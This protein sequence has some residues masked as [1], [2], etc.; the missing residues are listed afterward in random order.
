MRCA[1]KLS[2][3]TKVV[4]L[5]SPAQSRRTVWTPEELR[6]LAQFCLEHGLILVSDEIH[7]DLVFDGKHTPTLTAAPEIADSLITCGRR[8]QDLQ[9]RRRPCGRVLHVESGIEAP[10]RRAGA[11]ER[12]SAPTTASA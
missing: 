11:G 9:S 5:C 8:D 1:A 3:R 2:P 12:V 10:P 6:A 4:F 7:C